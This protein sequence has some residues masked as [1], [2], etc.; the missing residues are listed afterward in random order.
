MR[1]GRHLV[2]W[3]GECFTAEPLKS[4]YRVTSLPPVWPWR[5]GPIASGCISWGR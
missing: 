4:M 1:S 2:E 3:Q 5:Q